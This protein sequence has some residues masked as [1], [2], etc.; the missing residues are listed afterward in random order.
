VTGLTVLAYGAAPTRDD[1]VR[2]VTFGV[3]GAVTLGLLGGTA[4]LF[5]RRARAGRQRDE[6]FLAV[7]WLIELAA[8][9]VVSPWPAARR[10][11]GLIVVG[12]ILLGRC[13]GSTAGRPARRP[14]VVAVVVFGITIGLVVE[15]I[16]IDGAL[17]APDAIDR[18]VAVMTEVGP[19]EPTYYVGHWG[20][21]FYAERAG[22]RAIDPDR[23]RITAGSWIVVPTGDYA[24]QRI[25]IPEAATFVDHVDVSSR[26]PL[27]TIP[28]LHGTNA[29]LRRQV[30]PILSLDVYRASDDC[31]PPSQGGGP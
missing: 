4:I 18:T 16:D 20:L 1:V 5:I 22:W 26:W 31:V 7:W 9:V 27:A 6:L 28:W 15:A 24:R 8:A 30:G 29:P 13:A 21:Q 23:T 14:L 2:A 19:F 17:A 12:T 10:V 11:I 25:D 3:P